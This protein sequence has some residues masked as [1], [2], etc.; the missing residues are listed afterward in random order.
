M[1]IIS[2]PP[3]SGCLSLFFN[4]AFQTLAIDALPRNGYLKDGDLLP[5]DVVLCQ[6]DE[7]LEAVLRLHD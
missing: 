6:P 3:K 4:D 7:E 5:F 1:G 2:M